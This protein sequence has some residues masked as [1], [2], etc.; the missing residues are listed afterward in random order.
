MKKFVVFGNPIAHSLSP[1][2]HRMFGE[3][4]GIALQYTRCQVDIG[5]FE[6]AASAFFADPQAV[7]CNIT[8]PFKQDAFDFAEQVDDAARLAGAVNT[9]KK[10]N[11]SI[12][13]FNTDGIGLVNDLTSHR[14][15]LRHCR[16]IL[17]GAGGAARG[18]IHP[19]LNAGVSH[20]A[21]INRTAATAEKLVK[22]VGDQRVSVAQPAEAA[23]GE[24]NIIINSTSASLTQEL[25]QGLLQINMEKTQAVYD[26][27]YHSEPTAFMH[28]AARQGVPVQVDGLGMLVE[29]AAAAFTIWTASQPDTTPVKRYLR[30]QISQRQSR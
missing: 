26:M 16:I 13:G 24:A 9:L 27:V 2:I 14:L 10:E 22:E 25:P 8:V 17:L 7:G 23:M 28:Y 20:I 29:Q 21:I 12:L 6:R 15:P 18:V 11:N 3:S 19:L 5:G 30:E 4:T 1:E